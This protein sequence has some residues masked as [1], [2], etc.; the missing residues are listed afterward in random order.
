MNELDG[1]CTARV[2]TAAP[3]SL[4]RLASAKDNRG[5]CEKNVLRRG[6]GVYA[7]VTSTYGQTLHKCIGAS[8]GRGVEQVKPGQGGATPGPQLLK[9]PTKS[10]GKRKSR[11]VAKGRP[12]HPRIVFRHGIQTVADDSREGSFTCPAAFTAALSSSASNEMLEHWLIPKG[13][14]ARSYDYWRK[15]REHRAGPFVSP[16]TKLP[17]IPSPICCRSLRWTSLKFPFPR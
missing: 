4:N 7:Y 13:L 2:N 5:D 3:F 10:P 15:R 16:C 17:N 12:P 1:A 14:P 6:G 9:V 11:Q 8:G